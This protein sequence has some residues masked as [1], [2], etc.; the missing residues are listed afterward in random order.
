MFLT[1]IGF[2]VLAGIVGNLKSL[3]AFFLKRSW[4]KV[5]IAGDVNNKNVEISSAKDVEEKVR[6]F[7]DRNSANIALCIVL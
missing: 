6:H 5:I 7:M 1:K 2:T 4:Y 3:P